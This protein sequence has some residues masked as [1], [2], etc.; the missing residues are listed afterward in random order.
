MSGTPFLCLEE[1]PFPILES[2]YGWSYVPWCHNQI[3]FASIG[4]QFVQQW[5]KRRARISSATIT[6]KN[7]TINPS[8]TVAVSLERFY[9]KC[10]NWKIS[11]SGPRE[12]VAHRNAQVRLGRICVMFIT[13]VPRFSHFRQRSSI[14]FNLYLPTF[15]FLNLT[16]GPSQQ[17]NWFVTYLTA[18]LE[19]FTT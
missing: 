6:R 18:S 4:F 13:L 1:S 10:R 8:K 16:E 3:S 19:L 17:T 7:V 5:R 14:L 9:L 15:V 11:V 2:L 12:K